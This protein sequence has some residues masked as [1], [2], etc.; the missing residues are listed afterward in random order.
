MTKSN[1]LRIVKLVVLVAIFSYLLDKLVFISLSSLSNQ[2]FSGQKVG[3]LNHYL[4]V[5]DSMKILIFG[6]S[7]ANRHINT[8]LIS[9]QAFNMGV[10]GK[11]LAFTS[12]LVKLLPVKKQQLIIV[13]IDPQQLFDKSYDGSDIM[14]LAHKYHHIAIIAKSIDQSE[15]RNP[16]RNF[17][18]SLDYN[19]KSLSIIKHY[20]LPEYNH[21]KFTGYEPIVLS[22]KQTQTRAKKLTYATSNCDTLLK[23]NPLAMYHLKEIVSFCKQNNKKLLVVN[24]PYYHDLCKNDNI[25]M[26]RILKDLQVNFWDYGDYFGKKS[27]PDLWQ[28]KA[29]LSQ[30]GA[31][32]FSQGLS[33]KLKSTYSF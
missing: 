20:F 33:K 15:S 3:K 31:H 14:H 1:I 5:K 27:A 32:L 29:H 6:N 26:A 19:N 21:K 13:N 10:D 30:Q 12:T 25:L 28:D 8:T 16:L 24:T 22:K 7:R 2:V 11:G 23:I 17:Y 9:E 18:W 4:A